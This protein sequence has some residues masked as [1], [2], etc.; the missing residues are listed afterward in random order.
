MRIYTDVTVLAEQNGWTFARAEGYVDGQTSRKHGTVPP[1]YL[2]IRVDEY[3]R[4]FWAGYFT[5]DRKIPSPTTGKKQ[6]GDAA[7]LVP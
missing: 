4:G 2:A 3:C 1:T 5:T 6:F 7:N